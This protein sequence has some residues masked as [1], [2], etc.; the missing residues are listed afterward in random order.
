MDRTPPPLWHRSLLVESTSASGSYG[1]EHLSSRTQMWKVCRPNTILCTSICYSREPGFKIYKNVLLDRACGTYSQQGFV[2]VEATVLQ[3]CSDISSCEC[4]AL[5]PAEAMGCAQLCGHLWSFHVA[6]GYHLKY[7]ACLVQCLASYLPVLG[8]QGGSW[9]NRGK[10]LDPIEPTQD[11][12]RIARGGNSAL[13]SIQGFMTNLCANYGWITKSIFFHTEVVCDNMPVRI[14]VN[15]IILVEE[16]ETTQVL[17]ALKDNIYVSK[18]FS[19]PIHLFSGAFR[20][21]KGDLVLVAYSMIPGT[22]YINIDSVRPLSSQ[23]MQRACIT[24]LEGRNEVM[25]PCMF[26][27]LDYLHILP[28]YT[29]GLHDIVNMVAVDSIQL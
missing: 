4:V 14:G 18:D 6:D 15:V 12:G 29:P 23:N 9:D 16:D 1:K 21:F 11:P 22:S 26:F 19:F 7:V 13:M 27:T 3:Q 17:N 8:A 10:A 28:G 5:E 2:C 24:R 20:P 25:E